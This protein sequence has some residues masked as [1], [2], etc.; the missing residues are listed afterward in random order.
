MKKRTY[1]YFSVEPLYGCVYGLTYTRF[2]YGQLH[3]SAETLK[4]GERMTATVAVENAGKLAGDEVT[5]AYLIPPPG[6]NGGLSPKLQL[7]GYRRIHLDAGS[8]ETVTFE[9]DPRW[10]SQVDAEGNRSVQPGTYKLAIGGA[11]PDD[12]DASSPA[13]LGSFKVIGNQALPR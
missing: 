1:Q 10:I 12:P 4:A 6:G 3:L 13:V 5:E 11:Q 8:S 7:V 2:N 9:L